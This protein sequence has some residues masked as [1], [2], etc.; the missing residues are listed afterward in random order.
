MHDKYIQIKG[1]VTEIV[2]QDDLWCLTEGTGSSGDPI[3][4]IFLM[5]TAEDS[6]IFLTG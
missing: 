1:E 3:L 6:R 4:P 2:T 5:V